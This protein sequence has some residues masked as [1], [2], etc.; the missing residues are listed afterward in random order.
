LWGDRNCREMGINTDVK[1][2]FSSS[3]NGRLG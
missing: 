2:T 1:E 3:K